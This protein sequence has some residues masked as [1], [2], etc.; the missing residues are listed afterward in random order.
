MG[1]LAGPFAAGQVLR[2]PA[3]DHAVLETA[4]AGI[5]NDGLGF[6]RCD[7]AVVTN[8]AGDHL[9][10]AGLET[11]ADLARVKAVVPRAVVPEGASVLNA[12]DPLTAAMAEVAG[13]RSSSSRC[14]RTARSFMTT[15]SRG[16][17][18]WCCGRARQERC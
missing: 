17:V 1:D 15:S 7:V 16:A 12:D 11:L 9:G 14:V 6:D 8:V 13:G 10:Q 4:H 3:V 5:L 2:Y 18:R